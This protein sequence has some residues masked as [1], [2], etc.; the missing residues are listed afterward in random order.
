MINR[1]SDYII[2][3]LSKQGDYTQ[4]YMTSKIIIDISYISYESGQISII[5]CYKSCH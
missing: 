2:P 4:V 3:I 1:E 5:L